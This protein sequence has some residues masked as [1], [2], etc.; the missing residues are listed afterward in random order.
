MKEKKAT[1]V[2]IFVLCLISYGVLTAVIVSKRGKDTQLSN[3]KV[4]LFANETMDDYNT[5]DEEDGIGRLRNEWRELTGG[6]ISESEVKTN[7]EDD[8][9]INDMGCNWRELTGGPMPKCE[10]KP[11]VDDSDALPMSEEIKDLIP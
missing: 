11:I 8:G 1:I 6:P 9:S 4:N 2:V 3:N 5:S 10:V 7:N